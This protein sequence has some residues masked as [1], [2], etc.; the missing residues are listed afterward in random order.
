M[1]VS[2]FFVLS[3]YLICSMLLR[4]GM[5]T[6]PNIATFIGRRIGRIYPMYAVLLA[7]MAFFFVV[8]Q[9]QTLPIFQKNFLALA[10]FSRP[11]E[12]WM[13]YG[14][15]VLWTLYV[16]FWFYISFPFVLLAISAMP[17]RTSGA[18]KLLVSFGLIGATTFAVAMSVKIDP[19]I[20]NYD[21]FL[22]G[23]AAAVL[24]RYRDI[25]SW[26]GK[27]GA[28][29]GGFLIILAMITVPY[30]G[31]RNLAWHL[32]SITAAIGAVIVILASVASPPKYSLEPIAFVG[33][34]SYSI[35]LVHALV[36]D[37][38]VQWV[39][40]IRMLIVP[41][42]ACVVAISAMTYRFIEQPVIDVIHRRLK[43]RKP[44]RSVEGNVVEER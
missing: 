14:I 12:D 4:D 37:V 33:R 30:P 41:V 39:H 19:T 26:L 40:D 10:T 16:E 44:E 23:A 15:G 8:I 3:G 24:V 34:I 11:V 42:L 29:V 9:P 38:L 5:L 27:P 6:A 21:H 2:V 17:L 18:T 31:D 22:L 1:G 35:Y 7:A 28:S 25:P 13:G 43:F 20:A 32:Q 36:L